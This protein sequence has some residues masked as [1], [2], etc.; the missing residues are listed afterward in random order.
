MLQYGK[1][2]LIFC[3]VVGMFL[4]ALVNYEWNWVTKVEG[5]KHMMCQTRGSVFFMPI[6]MIIVD[7][8][9]PSD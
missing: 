8:P 2:L 7:I 6:F 5:G 3:L 4:L 9:N 1:V